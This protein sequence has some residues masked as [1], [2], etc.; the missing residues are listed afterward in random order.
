MKIAHCKESNIRL[1]PVRPL[2]VA[3]MLAGLSVVGDSSPAQT[4]SAG[5]G[6]NNFLMRARDTMRQGG[7]GAGTRGWA[8][9]Y[10]K[11]NG[12]VVNQ[13][14][15]INI[16]GLPANQSYHLMASFGT[17][18][19]LMHLADFTPNRSGAIKLNYMMGG[20]QRF[21]T[22]SDLSGWVG[23]MGGGSNHMSSVIY[24]S[25]VTN[26]CDWGGHHGGYPDAMSWAGGMGGMG[27][28]GGTNGVVGTQG[29]GWTGGMHMHWPA[30]ADWYSGMANWW[31]QMTNWCWDYMN[32][33]NGGAG[34][35]GGFN[36]WW[37]SRVGGTSHRMP[38][39]NAIAPVPAVNGLVV[40]DNNLQV[41]LA[42]D[43]TSP[44]TL[45]Y[46][47][48][49][50][51]IN[52]GV[53]AGAKARAVASAT[54]K[55]T[56]FMLTATG[57]APNTSYY[58]GADAGAATSFTTDAHGRFQTRTVPGGSSVTGIGTIWILDQNS[59]VVLSAEV[60]PL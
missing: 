3:V 23:P 37:G 6:N 19:G 52:H 56:H 29:M 27:G 45:Q 53:V 16:A 46:Q 4:A 20:K 24:P 58:W 32:G 51:F 9:S 48:H 54:Q 2:L 57:L 7:N 41:V 40:M 17:N 12:S 36:G 35:A 1:N 18:G 10:Y 55:G 43:L 42:S 30:M 14:L 21:T 47:A 34:S 60:S 28:T 8:S 49:C 31:P 13:S 50:D 44:S 22:T 38:M 59:N 39:P 11:R 26:W 33:W 25:A 5:T 15:Q